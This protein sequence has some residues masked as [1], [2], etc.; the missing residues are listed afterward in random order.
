MEHTLQHPIGLAHLII[1]FLAIVIGT[2]VILSRKGTRKHRWLGRGYVCTMV[3]VNVS[4]FL[5]Y[6]LFGGFG[7][8]HWMALASLLTVLVGYIPARLRGPGWKVQHAY[9]MCGSY[10]GLIAAL[11]AETL[12]RTPWLPF[13]DAVVVA[14]ISVIFLG[15]LL[16]FRI[17]P[18]LL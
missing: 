2:L 17:I 18:R 14:S 1:A 10:V 5:I 9:F 7:L 16:M 11:A 13:F 15:I 4:A 6:E 3:A 8:F 12:T